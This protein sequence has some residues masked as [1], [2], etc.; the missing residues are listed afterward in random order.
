MGIG[1][2]EARHRV[3]GNNG[4]AGPM[5]GLQGLLEGGSDRRSGD[6]RQGPPDER[7]SAPIGA[8]GEAKGHLSGDLG[9]SLQAV[10][11]GVHGQ[12]V[13]QRRLQVAAGG[14]LQP[15]RGPR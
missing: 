15:L 2:E 13:P 12:D 14:A 10:S 4:Q 1:A 9:R 5:G 6:G 11:W 3:D 7:D 8:H